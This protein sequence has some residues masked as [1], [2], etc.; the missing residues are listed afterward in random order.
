MLPCPSAGE[1]TGP[2]W[3]LASLWSHSSRAGQGASWRVCVSSAGPASRGA[4]FRATAHSRACTGL[5]S[6]TG[7]RSEAC[8]DMGKK[9]RQAVDMGP[10]LTAA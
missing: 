2:E 9:Y 4:V 6:V 1:E 7:C 8:G 5:P 3:L 10:V